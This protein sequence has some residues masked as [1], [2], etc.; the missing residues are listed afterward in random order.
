MDLKDFVSASLVQFAEGVIDAQAKLEKSGVI[1]SPFI[2]KYFSSAKE[3]ALF[4]GEDSKGRLIQAISFDVAVTVERG[5]QTDGRIS[6]AAGLLGLES[7]G[8]T[9]KS[10]DSVSRIAFVVPV[11]LGNEFKSKTGN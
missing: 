2:S 7:K 6:I 9:K 1:I 8:Q 11:S 10:N 4:I 5:T 3:N